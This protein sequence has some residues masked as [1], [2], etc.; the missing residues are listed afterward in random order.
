MKWLFK[1]SG[2]RQWRAATDEELHRKL[3][4]P[5]KDHLFSLGGWFVSFLAFC[6]ELTIYATRVAQ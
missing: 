2:T 6:V 3:Q 4:K 5:T 1:A